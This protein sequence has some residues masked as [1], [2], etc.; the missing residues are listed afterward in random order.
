MM[1]VVDNLGRASQSADDSLSHSILEFLA[2]FKFTIMSHPL[3][4]DVF[5]KKG[6]LEIGWGCEYI[7]KYNYWII[8]II[9]RGSGDSARP[10]VSWIFY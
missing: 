6:F 8:V 3:F 9:L 1:H 7:T 10:V 2:F 4:F 5:V